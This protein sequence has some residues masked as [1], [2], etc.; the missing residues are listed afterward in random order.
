MPIS[1]Y[2]VDQHYGDKVIVTVDVMGQSAVSYQWLRNDEALSTAKDSAIEGLGTPKLTIF[3]FT[4]EYEGKYRCS[5]NFS[6]GEVVKSR[7]IE[8]ALGKDL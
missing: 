4:H 5:V 8:L 6:S 3:P 7:H 1:A 2:P